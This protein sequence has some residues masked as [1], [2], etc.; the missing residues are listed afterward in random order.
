MRD[1][2]VFFSDKEEFRATLDKMAAEGL[3]VIDGKKVRELEVEAAPSQGVQEDAEPIGEVLSATASE[4]S[5]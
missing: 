2:W 4:Q 3:I 5:E 1:N